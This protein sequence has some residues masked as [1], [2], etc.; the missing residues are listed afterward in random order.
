MFYILRVEENSD[1]HQHI[2]SF[3]GK[4]PKLEK[5]EVKEKHCINCGE[6]IK[7]RANSNFC[8]KTCYMQYRY[9]N[10]LKKEK[11]SKPKLIQC[12]YCGQDFTTHHY[13]TK[14]CSDACRK[15]AQKINQHNFYCKTRDLKASV[16]KAAKERRLEQEA[17]VKQR[18]YTSAASKKLKALN[19]LM[20]E[21]PEVLK[22]DAN[23]HKTIPVRINSRTTIFI[24]PGQDPEEARTKYLLKHKM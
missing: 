4:K 18:N 10:S 3:F 9:K 13:L 2:E 22:P 6:K 24:A 8:N 19:N 15:R 14:Y 7:P 23:A 11:E 12:Q 5:V 21:V 1:L 17:V 20:I 16:K